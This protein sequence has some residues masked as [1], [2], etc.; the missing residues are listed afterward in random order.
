MTGAGAGTA[1]ASVDA[2]DPGS[3]IADARLVP[4]PPA[5]EGSSN[6]L[7]TLE[8][9]A[10]LA[11]ATTEGEI[12]KDVSGPV[13]RGAVVSLTEA[14]AESL[15]ESPGV[16]AVEPDSLVSVIEDTKRPM[17]RD[18]ASESGVQA[19][20]AA[21]SWGL[22][23]TDQRYLPLDG[24][25]TGPG[26]GAGVHVYVLDSGID[27][28]HPD[29]AG[30]IGTGAYAFGTSPQD[31]H[32]HGTHVAGTIGSTNHGVANGVTFHPVK[33]TDSQGMGSASTIIAGMNW[34]A[35]NAPARSV[36]NISL[37]LPYSQAL[38]DAAGALVDKGMV[39]VAAAG[40]EGDDAQNHSPASELSILT[41]GAVDQ[42]DRD[43]TFSNFGTALDLYAPGVAIRSTALHGGS[44]V[45]TGTSMAAPHVAGAAAIYWGM[46]PSAS[47]G[48]VSNAV[49]S[50]ATP[51]V[52]SF[53]FGQ[54]GSPNV[55]LHVG[56]T[57]VV[58][59]PGSPTAVTAV[60]GNASAVVS[61]T[62]PASNGGSAITGYF[63]EASPGGNS[64]ATSGATSCTVTGLMN[65]SPYLFTVRASN[66]AGHGPR[67][68]HSA[69]VTPT[70]AAPP[71]SDEFVG[72]SPVRAADTRY[73]TGVRAG[74]VPGGSVLEVPIAGRY[75]IPSSAGA[76]S[77]N[78]TVTQ[79]A[80][81]GHIIVFP[82]GQDV[83]LASSLNYRPGQTVPNMVIAPIGDGGRVCLYTHAK[84][85]LVVDVNGWLPD[86]SQYYGF[87]PQR[88]FDTRD[89]DWPLE[90]GETVSLTI[91]DPG[92][93]A[94][95]SMNVTVTQPDSAGHIIVYPCDQPRPV[96][97]NLNYVQGQ[98]VPNAVIAQVD[99]NG[100]VCFYSHAR[101]HLIADINGVFI[102]D[103]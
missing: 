99:A 23:R 86:D 21:S 77:L 15:K 35:A 8:D 11:S 14:E 74:V 82:C 45:M 92:E 102:A 76:V 97:S 50:Q 38:N 100:E 1:S 66:S 58:S 5:P 59:V 56:W 42:S 19:T 67:S 93:I 20:A 6:Y 40:N 36:V 89:D 22:D 95:V 44:T 73:G 7:V 54:G 65:G 49:K 101:T 83:P 96:A 85:H 68:A 103:V 18:Q 81:A 51:G 88:A 63:V 10:P 84:A 27:Y 69:V 37:G 53:P 16:A 71:T 52:V 24:K 9:G 28:G 64:C 94:A 98:T 91:G 70:A 46:Y 75:G 32:G 47:G 12:A 79:P 43:T 30:R 34:I 90:P 25:Y 17:D 41:V 55:N 4:A 78:V 60:P 48:A 87:S 2:P 72:R 31:D 61:W 13:F 80:A 26:N 3:G 62:A 33:V 39:V 29:F 57:P